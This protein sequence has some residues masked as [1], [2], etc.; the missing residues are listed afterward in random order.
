MIIG[1][2]RPWNRDA[3][4]ENKG[5]WFLWKATDPNVLVILYYITVY[6]PIL[7]YSLNY[8]K[9]EIIYSLEFVPKE[10]PSSLY[11]ILIAFP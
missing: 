6:L 10:T 5:E 2:E 11:S 1:S 9:Y 8:Y 4:Q 3:V 7:F